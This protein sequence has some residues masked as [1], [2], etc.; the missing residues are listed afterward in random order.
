MT[1]QQQQL[2]QVLLRNGFQLA[3]QKK[4][5]V[6]RHPDGRVW[7]MPRTPSD[8]RALLNNFTELKNFL[9]RGKVRGIFGLTAIDESERDAFERTLHPQAK[10]KPKEIKERNFGIA[11]ER[12]R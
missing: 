11:I 9:D 12:I 4:H 8:K 3:R 7:T 1:P 2:T 5:F 6:W 10:Q